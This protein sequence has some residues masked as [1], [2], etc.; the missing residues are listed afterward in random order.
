[1]SDTDNVPAY[2]TPPRRARVVTIVWGLVIIVVAALFGAAELGGY[3]FNPGEVLI[4]LLVGSGVA[5]I[6]GGIISAV[7]GRREP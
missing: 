2:D 3:R 5:L 1:M 4:W 6:A 7:R